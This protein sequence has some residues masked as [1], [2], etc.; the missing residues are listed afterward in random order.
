M[1]LHDGEWRPLNRA[2]RMFA[3]GQLILWGLILLSLVAIKA[4]GQTTQI[5][6]DDV[7]RFIASPRGIANCDGALYFADSLPKS[8]VNSGKIRKL[9]GSTYTMLATGLNGPTSVACGPSGSVYVTDSGADRIVQIDGTS[10]AVTVLQT[11]P[12]NTWPRG[13]YADGGALTWGAWSP[14]S[15]EGSSVWRSLTPTGPRSRL[16]QAPVNSLSGV[17]GVAPAPNGGAYFTEQNEQRL[18]LTVP[19][20]PNA[21][22]TLAGDGWMGT[23][24]SGQ[25]LAQ[26]R[27]NG[28]LDLQLVG[29]DLYILDSNG[30]RRAIGITTLGSAAPVSTVYSSSLFGV[31]TGFL[32]DGESGPLYVSVASRQAV[33]AFGELAP[34]PTATPVPATATSVPTSP[35]ATATRTLPPTAV[36]TAT[37]PGVPMCVVPCRIPNGSELR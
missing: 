36:P 12:L 31:P 4:Q 1:T 16:Y 6:G 2:E 26:C 23:C 3:L 15:S 35:P 21:P 33:W 28:P 24:A 18:K 13:L 11:Q 32:K 17:W 25:T 22:I 9:A 27:F 10:G 8:S 14:N 30:I 7:G 19:G 20:Q 29:S 34:Q 37:A 5:L